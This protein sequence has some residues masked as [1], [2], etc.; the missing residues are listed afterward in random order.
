MDRHTVKQ[1]DNGDVRIWLRIKVDDKPSA[2]FLRCHIRKE[3]FAI[4]TLGV[5]IP[6]ENP[7]IIDVKNSNEWE[8]SEPNTT[9][10]EVSAFL[11]LMATLIV[12]QRRANAPNIDGRWVSM[13][14]FT[15]L[16]MDLRKRARVLEGHVE[17]ITSGSTSSFQA[18]ASLDGGEVFVM[19]L[20]RDPEP[21]AYFRLVTAIIGDGIALETVL[22][23]SDLPP[24]PFTLRRVD[25]DFS[26]Q[27]A[28]NIT[29]TQYH[30]G[31]PFEG[32]PWY[33]RIGDLMFAFTFVQLTDGETGS[34]LKGFADMEGRDQKQRLAIDG[35][36]AVLA[37]NSALP[38]VEFSIGEHYMF[39]GFLAEIGVLRG[40]VEDHDQRLPMVI[41][42]QGNPD[43]LAAM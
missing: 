31:R 27:Y 32:V 16:R 1:L 22:G 40:F 21:L 8:L 17:L 14:G 36:I 9:P 13:A 11:W 7:P 35:S 29:A 34:I 41:S 39:T 24:I 10:G 23:R 18:E 15:E 5:V 28:I 2:Q 37:E 30:Q 26:P 3:D 33:S 6:D 12:E 42:R 25:D 4:K 43:L 38:Q 20:R 19:E